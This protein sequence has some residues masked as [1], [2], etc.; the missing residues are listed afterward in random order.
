[1]KVH[2]L[3]DCVANSKALKAGK[4]YDLDKQVAQKLINRGFCTDKMPEKKAKT[5]A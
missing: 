1:M 2:V 3:K 4:E 5:K